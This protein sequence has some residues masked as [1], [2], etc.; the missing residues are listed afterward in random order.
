M[1]IG[2]QDLQR[3]YKADD[4]APSLMWQPSARD[5]TS[6]PFV[7]S[8]STRPRLLNCDDGHEKTSV[9]GHTNT[10]PRQRAR[11]QNAAISEGR[12]VSHISP[13]S[14]IKR[15]M[16]KRTRSPRGPLYWPSNS[17]LDGL[18]EDDDGDENAGSCSD[19]VASLNTTTRTYSNRVQL[20]VY[21]LI[22][23]D[24]MVQLPWGCLCHIGKCFVNLNDTLHILGTGAY[25]VGIE[26]NDVEYAYGATS[27]PHVSGVFSCAPRMSPGYQYRKTIDYGVRVVTNNRR[28]AEPQSDMQSTLYCMDG[29]Q[30]MRQMSKEYMGIDYDILRKNCCTFAREALLRLGIND[31]EIPFWFRNLAESGAI[32]QDLAIATVEPL[33]HV[34]SIC[35]ESNV[36]VEECFEVMDGSAMRAG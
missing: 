11:S 31:S 20:H 1:D 36:T 16:L 4:L 8:L 26:I 24:S 33:V 9:L 29:K 10:L 28:S 7:L 5:I 14:V 17:I 2:L 12:D 15:I 22:R 23:S 34:L 6:W 19:Q 32:T 35:E 18:Q 21:D 27:T 25:H 30:L 3:M 13:T